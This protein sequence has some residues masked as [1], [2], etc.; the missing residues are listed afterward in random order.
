MSNVLEAMFTVDDLHSKTEEAWE[1]FDSAPNPN[2]NS[3]LSVIASFDRPQPRCQLFFSMARRA[4]DALVKR[5]GE[6][7]ISLKVLGQMMRGRPVIWPARVVNEPH[8]KG[9][10]ETDDVEDY[11][12]L[13]F[14]R[15]TFNAHD[16]L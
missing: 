2:R 16:C 8:A 15:S 10:D 1:Y 13:G 14:D 11:P 3:P 7:Q 12:K 5:P 6:E 4:G 9:Q